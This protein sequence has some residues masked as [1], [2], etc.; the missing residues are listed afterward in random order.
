MFLGVI[1]RKPNPLMQLMLP[2]FYLSC[3]EM[4][5]KWEKIA[6]S[7]GSTFELDVSPHLQ[8]L[9]SDAISR[10]AFGTSYEEGRKIVELQKELATLL[11]KAFL[12]FFVPGLR[13][14]I[15]RCSS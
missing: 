8:S 7:E 13:L 5:S 15:T 14:Y 3:C 6:Q 11:L 1:L 2:S 4:L 10:T 12:L 9:T